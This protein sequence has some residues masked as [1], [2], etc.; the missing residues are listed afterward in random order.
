MKGGTSTPQHTGQ[1]SQGAP[2]PG[3]INF[4][5]NGG[6]G[7]NAGVELGGDGSTS[8]GQH[9]SSTGTP[10]QG[11]P[12]STNDDMRQR[13]QQLEYFVVLMRQQL[14]NPENTDMNSPPSQAQTSGATPPNPTENVN[15]SRSTEVLV[16]GQRQ[17]GIN[18]SA[19]ILYLPRQKNPISCLWPAMMAGVGGGGSSTACCAAK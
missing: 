1:T 3:N 2:S 6:S 16:P 18:I 19:F 8:A 12:P 13:L 9:A 10:W 4:Q 14:A 17:N 15:E 5:P 7:N 11:V